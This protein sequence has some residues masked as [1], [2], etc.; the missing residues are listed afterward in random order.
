VQ[1]SDAISPKQGKK[2]KERPWHLN[3]KIRKVVRMEV[4]DA[5][6]MRGKV[7]AGMMGGIVLGLAA[8][9][10]AG[11]WMLMACWR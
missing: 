3:K 2:T 1:P 6:E 4:S 8:L 10:W 7:M 11:Y 9:G 5:F